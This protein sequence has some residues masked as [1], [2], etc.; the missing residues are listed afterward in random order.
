MLFDLEDE[1]EEE[2]EEDNQ[3][4]L[5]LIRGYLNL[6]RINIQYLCLFGEGYQKIEISEPWKELEILLL[7]RFSTAN[8]LD[9]KRQQ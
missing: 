5:A 6:A 9:L 1:E 4:C 2:D 3:N 8:G 7:F